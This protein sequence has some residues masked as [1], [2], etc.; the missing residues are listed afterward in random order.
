MDDNKTDLDT[1]SQ[2]V[3]LLSRRF[4][5][6]T[7][8]TVKLVHWQASGSCCGGAALS[9]GFCSYCAMGNETGGASSHGRDTRNSF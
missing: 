9:R 7:T 4:E 8:I 1:P 3:Y 6:D 5:Q 2:S